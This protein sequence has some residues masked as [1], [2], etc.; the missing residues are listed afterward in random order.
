MSFGKCGEV[1]A[2]WVDV[3][4]SHLTFLRTNRIIC[5]DLVGISKLRFQHQDVYIAHES[6]TEE[7][8]MP[9]IY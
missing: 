7:I 2:Q 5:Q 1:T 8:E 9:V 3:T 4:I 6:E